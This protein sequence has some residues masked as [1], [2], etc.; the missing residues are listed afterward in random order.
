VDQPATTWDE[1]VGSSLRLDGRVAIV[2][3]AANGI[4]REIAGMLG[5]RGAA[6]CLCDRDEDALAAA[7]GSLEEAAVDVIA[8]PTDITTYG[9]VE[10]AVVAA[11]ERWGRVD[12]LVN[13][14]GIG[15]MTAPVWEMDVDDWKAVLDVNLNGAFYFSRA[16]APT[17]IEQR[18]GRIV[19]IASIA[20]KEGNPTSSHYSASKAGLIALTKCLGKELATAGVHVHAVAPAVIRTGILDRP[21][22]DPGFLDSL[23]AKIPMQRFGTTDEVAR[24]VGFLVSDEL[25]FST[26]AV[27]DLSGGRATY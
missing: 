10:R 22:V 27:F 21:G 25:T 16:V 24:L 2:T 5:G 11:L 19:N 14:A 6:V 20:G 17:M 15:G 12:I 1:P 18:Y 7:R 9:D 8:C 4:G 23:T 13:C 3:G 26:G